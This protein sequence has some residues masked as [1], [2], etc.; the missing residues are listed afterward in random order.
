MIHDEQQAKQLHIGPLT[1]EEYGIITILTSDE[2]RSVLLQSAR[3]RMK[4]V[5]APLAGRPL[6][7][8]SDQYV[9]FA[10]QCV[11]EL[12][13]Q[14]R[15]VQQDYLAEV[16]VFFVEVAPQHV[17]QSLGHL[18][19]EQRR[20]AGAALLLRQFTQ[21]LRQEVYSSLTQKHTKLFA[22]DDG[23]FSWLQSDGRYLRQTEFELKALL[24]ELFLLCANLPTS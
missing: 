10:R 24:K 5:L 11:Q 22:Q 3:D 17:F 4:A 23:I 2:Q 1:I 8:S 15:S 16:R 6:L 9:D 12:A 19:G 14:E 21:F 18:V 7:L 13:L 20:S